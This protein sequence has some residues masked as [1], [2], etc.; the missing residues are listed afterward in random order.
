MSRIP[1]ST[2][3][4]RYKQLLSVLQELAS[5][6]NTESLQERIA[7]SAAELSDG[8]FSWILFPDQINSSLFFNSSNLP[9][10]THHLGFSAPVNASLEGWAFTNKTP[11]MVNDPS[12]Y[13]LRYGHF[14]YIPGIEV[15]SLL[16]IPIMTRGKC[17]GVL[18]VINKST[19]EFT[20][21]DQEILVSFANQVA[22]YIENTHRF[23]QSDLVT[24]LVHELH[25]P[26]AGLNTA[27]YLLQRP[28]LPADRREQLS[29]MIHNEFNRLSE[30]TT[31]FLD[32]ARMESG[33]TKIIYSQFDFIQL[34]KE[35]IDI[36]QMQMDGKDMKISIALP[37]EALVINADKDKI[38]Q[39]ILNLLSNADK[40]NRPGGLIKV[41]ANSSLVDV[42]FSIQDSG[43]GIPPEY[44][45]RLFERF[46]RIPITEKG[47]KGTGL[48]LTIC[49]Q[50][51]EAHKGKIEVS[52]TVG[53]GST[54]TV[55]L[56][57]KQES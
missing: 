53:N 36:F 24:E 9:I 35:S 44:L 34:I 43:P 11:V 5:I 42:S 4:N 54:F 23:L 51:V 3:A 27:L 55:F 33:R 48:G 25:T 8:E 41:S 14:I 32:Y 7:D 13:D 10:N 1:R 50:I 12:L 31:S 29:Q 38:K 46:Y 47:V 15:K 22:I 57:Y 16:A 21:I 28:D 40:Y 45:P 18:E 17:I 30:L 26:L 52:S 6:L 37:S 49:K 2:T 19:Q 20:Q 56:P 39:V